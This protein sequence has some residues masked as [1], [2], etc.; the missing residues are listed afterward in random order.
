MYNNCNRICRED[1]QKTCMTCMKS[2]LI[3]GGSRGIGYAMT[4]LFLANDYKVYA[5]YNRTKGS[6]FELQKTLPNPNNLIPLPVELSN[7]S[8]ID[9]MFSKIER[10]LDVLINNASISESKLFDKITE[11]DWDQIQATNLKAYFLLAQKVYPGM[12]KQKSGCIINIGSIWGVTGAA[13]EVHYSTMKAGIIG[14][15]KALAKE[16]APCNVR[17]NAIAPGAIATDMLNEYTADEIKT[18]IK[19]IPLLRLGKPEEIA[20][21]AL[22]LAEQEYITGEVIN[23]NGGLWI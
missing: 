3:T 20:Q 4:S 22:F 13:C 19:E 5:T 23:V 8:E 15:T 18:L 12:V 2:V 11:S 10:P 16:L 1:E 14:L 7:K 21:T 9:L 17:V 6:L